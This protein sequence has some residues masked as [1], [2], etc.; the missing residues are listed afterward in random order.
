MLSSGEW[1]QNKRFL[2]LRSNLNNDSAPI[3]SNK[4]SDIQGTFNVGSVRS[5]HQ[6][7]SSRIRN[8]AS[9]RTAL[10]GLRNSSYLT[11]TELIDTTTGFTTN[12]P[13][14]LVRS[15][16]GCLQNPSVQKPGLCPT[17]RYKK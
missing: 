12:I 10:I 8:I 9:D 16:C 3:F 2:G 15:L 4:R 14:I 11:K 7:G 6:T 13:V 17:C 1:T 5:I